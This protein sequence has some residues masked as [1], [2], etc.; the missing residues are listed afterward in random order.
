MI[1]GTNK[2]CLPLLLIGTILSDLFVVD[3]VFIVAVTDIESNLSVSV[4]I[5]K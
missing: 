5:T 2:F 1:I 4:S 3:V